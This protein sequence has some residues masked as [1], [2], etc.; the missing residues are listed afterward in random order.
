MT[1]A[2]PNSPTR[3]VEG[4]AKKW[5][6]AVITTVRLLNEQIQLVT[7]LMFLDCVIGRREGL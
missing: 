4:D 2:G 1:G 6:I 3:A 5:L 7:K